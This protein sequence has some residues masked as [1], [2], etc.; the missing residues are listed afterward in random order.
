MDVMLRCIKVRKRYITLVKRCKYAADAAAAA[1]GTG[2]TGSNVTAFSPQ[3][4]IELRKIED[5]IPL[6]ALLVFRQF[7][8]Y[9]M[10]TE[11]K[12]EEKESHKEKHKIPSFGWTSN[13]NSNN[14]KNS[15]G[16]LSN[17]FGGKKSNSSS[18]GRTYNPSASSVS[19]W[20]KLNLKKSKK[21]KDSSSSSSSSLGG[22]GV[23][24]QKY[25]KSLDRS[26]G[27]DEYDDNEED[28]DRL[29]D[30]IQS[31]L[32]LDPAVVD[33]FIF[34]LIIN[35]STALRL[36]SESRPVALLELS[37][38]GLTEMKADGIIV[39]FAVEDFHLIDE[40][41]VDPLVRYLIICPDYVP[42]RNQSPRAQAHPHSQPLPLSVPVPATV[43][44][45]IAMRTTARKGPINPFLPVPV[46]VP[47]PISY[48]STSSSQFLPVN[49][50]LSSP[51]S[52]SA[53]PSY[54]STSVYHNYRKV[55]NNN[56]ALPKLLISI[57]SRN[58]KSTLRLNIRP[59]EATWNELCVGRLLGIFMSPDVTHSIPGLASNTATNSSSSTSSSSS[60]SAT[61]SPIIAASMNK[62]AL[63][64]ALPIAGEMELIIEIDAPKIII[65]DNCFRDNGC[66]LADAG[67][68]EIRGTYAYVNVHLEKPWSNVI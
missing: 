58:G 40:C 37:M 25:S 53:V 44:E 17:G 67:Y 20:F 32:D 29:I 48:S 42:S 50:S 57:D 15:T 61:F 49:S 43:E 51:L 9:E 3:D 30:L 45:K 39:T 27:I 38:S 47:S 28:D 11:M 12:K 65:P 18:T 2:S 33:Q 41:T 22:S 14:E 64:A 46:P 21:L 31:R 55:D 60:S 23:Q 19:S 5:L 16:G 13:S 54:D 36:T 1:G 6:Q 24:N 10:I 52:S 56:K 8:A 7:A 26:V 59:M 66:L 35:A 63:E 4:E 68:L 62:F 34:R